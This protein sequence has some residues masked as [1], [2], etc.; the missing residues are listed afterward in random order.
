[1]DLRA[2]FRGFVCDHSPRDLSHRDLLTRLDLKFS[3][4]PEFIVFFVKFLISHEM[5][6]LGSWIFSDSSALEINLLPKS[7]I[8]L[9]HDSR[10]QLELSFSQ[11]SQE[12]LLALV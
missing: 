6:D 11:A 8:K 2:F 9:F 7:H 1:M 5:L 4:L 3:S 12:N 10:D